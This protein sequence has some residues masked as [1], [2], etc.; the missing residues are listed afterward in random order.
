MT[1]LVSLALLSAATLTATW[2]FAR[3][4]A[5]KPVRIRAERR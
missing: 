1:T 3:A 4:R 2:L 5:P